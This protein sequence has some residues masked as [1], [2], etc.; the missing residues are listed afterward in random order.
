MST[1]QTQSQRPD[2][3]HMLRGP[4]LFGRPAKRS[5]SRRG[6][7]GSSCR[8]VVGFQKCKSL[9]T[10]M[11]AVSDRCG[12]ASD[13]ENCSVLPPR[14]NLHIRGK[15][16]LRRAAGM[17]RS[18]TEPEQRSHVGR[19]WG[20]S[21]ATGAAAAGQNREAHENLSQSYENLFFLRQAVAA[22]CAGGQLPVLSAQP[23]AGRGSTVRSAR[24]V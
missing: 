8:L 11:R 22:G 24:P 15:A 9:A 4:L 12:R 20:A 7:G 5:E 13:L 17:N 6:A 2:R 10:A 23:R 21:V 19:R 3:M 18:K 16:I 14:G 1:N